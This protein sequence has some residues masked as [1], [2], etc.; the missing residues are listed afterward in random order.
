MRN[1]AVSVRFGAVE[2][3]IWCDSKVRNGAVSV[4]FGAKCSDLAS[5]A[6]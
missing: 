3:E 5:K 6:V 1:G 2:C 4:R